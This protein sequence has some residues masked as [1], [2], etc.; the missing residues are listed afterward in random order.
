MDLNS[1]LFFNFPA[2]W[3]DNFVCKCLINFSFVIIYSFI[4]LL[5]VLNIPKHIDWIAQG[6]Q[7]V[8]QLVRPLAI[9]HDHLEDERKQRSDPV[10]EPASGAFLYDLL[11]VG[12]DL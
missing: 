3:L 9:S 7:E 2:N 8:V 11:P 4:W 12:H 6:H 1:D 10:N 5:Q